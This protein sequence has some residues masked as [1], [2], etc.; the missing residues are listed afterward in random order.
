MKKFFTNLSKYPTIITTAF[1]GLVY[2]VSVSAE[3]Y[4]PMIRYDRVWECRSSATSSGYS[5]G[6]NK[7]MRFDGTEEFNGKEYHRLVTFKK[8]YPIIEPG[9]QI[10]G[11][12]MEDC[13]EHEGYMR[14]ED[15][16]V[17]TLFVP[18]DDSDTDYFVGRLYIPDSES[19]VNQ[20]EC[21]EQLLY[22]LTLNEDDVYTG[23]SF[24]TR[25][26]ELNAFKVLN[27]SSIE[28]G[29]EDLKMMKVGWLLQYGAEETDCIGEY[30]VVEGVGAIDSGC[31]NHY[32]F[33]EHLT[34]IW[35]CNY[36]LR[37]F[38][39][40]GNLLYGAENAVR[41]NGLDWGSFVS[42]VN[43]VKAAEEPDN[44]IYDILG[45]RITTPAPGQLYIQDGKKHIAK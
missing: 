31:L 45:S 9:G 18:Y 28:I 20:S 10:T 12:E 16:K 8:A 41:Y 32:E 30:P 44:S 19:P 7:C 35:C 37:L 21:R 2:A 5:D 40:E 15:G 27:V 26:A 13:Y 25:T 23:M 39:M 11:Y 3:E 34:S 38:D 14:E 17:Y 42:E 33:S 29:G 24:V 6:V 4:K 22:D 43:T 1:I 36:F